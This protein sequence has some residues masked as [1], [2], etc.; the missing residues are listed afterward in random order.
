[1][2]ATKVIVKDVTAS[3]L[4]NSDG[5]QL[6]FVIDNSLAEGNSVILSFHDVHTIS[7]SF[8]NSSLGNIIDKYGF[9]TLSRIKI[10][11][12]TSSIASFIKKYISDMKTLSVQ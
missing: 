1:M 11:D 12:Y 8:L 10:I 2:K 6:Q 4:S 5:V 3:T 7:S 9:D